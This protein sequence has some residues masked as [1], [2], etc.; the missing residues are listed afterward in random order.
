MTPEDYFIFASFISTLIAAVIFSQKTAHGFDRQYRLLREETVELE[1]SNQALA[2]HQRQLLILQHWSERRHNLPLTDIIFEALQLLGHEMSLA[3]AA[4][5]L[6]SEK[7]AV[8][9]W[10]TSESF[11]KDLTANDRI[12]GYKKS[13]GRKQLY[14]S[15]SSS[16]KK[17][18]KH[19]FIPLTV[20]ENSLGHLIIPVKKRGGRF[21]DLF[22]SQ[23]AVAVA[24]AKFDIISNELAVREERQKIARHIYWDLAAKIEDILETLN[25]IRTDPAKLDQIEKTVKKG[26]HQLRQSLIS[27]RGGN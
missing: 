11:V 17:S 19:T 24:T 22:I 5:A 3:K 26:A 21:L 7:D 10:S 6:R 14:F 8:E 9:I 2:L 27:L 25:E 18:P 15:E 20:G 1:K 23:L 13:S 4:L 16:I 12:I